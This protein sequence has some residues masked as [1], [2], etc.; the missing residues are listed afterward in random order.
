[1][2]V[3]AANASGCL[4]TP[5]VLDVFIYDVTPTIN[6]L[7]PF[8]ET[9]PCVPLVANPS[10]GVFSGIGVVGNDFWP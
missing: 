8:C 6:A 1:M 9:D 7:G 5:S 2:T 3:D 4:S 10:G